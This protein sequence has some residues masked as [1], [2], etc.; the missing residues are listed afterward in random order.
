MNGHAYLQVLTTGA[1][2]QIDY[3]SLRKAASAWHDEFAALPKPLVVVN[4][5][6]PRSRFCLL[7]YVTR[8]RSYFP[9]SS[10]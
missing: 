10:I 3:S 5:G 6:W 4:I 7:F 1:L 9:V 8:R 2:H